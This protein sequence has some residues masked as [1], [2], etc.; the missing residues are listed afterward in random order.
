M[1]RVLVADDSAFIRKNLKM[2]FSQGGHTVVAEATSGYE[3]FTE[4][5][6]TKPDLVTMDIT[7]PAMN[8]I[9]T[10]KKILAKY[11][12]AN[13]VVISAMDQKKMVFDAIESGAK[14]YIIK[15]ITAEKVL[16][17]TDDVLQRSNYEGEKRYS[18]LRY[19][20]GGKMPFSIQN[21]NGLFNILLHS[22]INIENIQDLIRAM[23]GFLV[24]RPIRVVM[25]FS[26]L[27]TLDDYLLDK[28]SEI[29]EY[30]RDNG[31]EF[32][33][34]TNDLLLIQRAKEKGSRLFE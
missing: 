5:E 25:D 19:I 13:I 29:A 11:P 15:P 1:A 6:R 9:E 4:Y 14:H 24:I 23:K 31:G 2:V 28:F 8:G 21:I 20:G 27:M 7:M 12:E 18:M 16:N 30:I 22:N 17:I 3:T 26:E 34:T 33:G 10:T 32:K